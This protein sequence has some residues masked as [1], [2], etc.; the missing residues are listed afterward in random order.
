[1]LEIN[2][3]QYS[4]AIQINKDVEF[5][6]NGKDDA[7]RCPLHNPIV[8]DEVLDNLITFKWYN[9]EI[10]DS[11][12]KL[13][14]IRNV[15]VFH[16]GG[17]E[18]AKL[19]KFTSTKT[20]NGV[21]LYGLVPCSTYYFTFI[22]K[23][24]GNT[25]SCNPTATLKVDTN[26]VPP[27]RIADLRLTAPT[28][29]QIGVELVPIEPSL[30]S[31]CVP[32]FYFITLSTNSEKVE[33]ISTRNTSYQ[34]IGSFSPKTQYLVQVQAYYQDATNRGVALLKEII[35]PDE[36]RTV[37]R[38]PV[39]S[40]VTIAEVGSNSMRV[41]WKMS[42]PNS[43]GVYIFVRVLQ[44]GV[45][46][47]QM[48]TVF[49]LSIDS[50]VIRDLLPCNEY[51]VTIVQ[52]RIANRVEIVGQVMK[53]STRT[54]LPDSNSLLPETLT[55]THP[56]D[57][58]K[59]SLTIYTK[60]D[61]KCNPIKVDY[62]VE[63]YAMRPEITTPFYQMKHVVTS[64]KSGVEITWTDIQTVTLDG[65]I[66]VATATN[67]AKQWIKVDPKLR[68]AN[69]TNLAPCEKYRIFVYARSSE[70]SMSEVS[71]TVVVEM[72]FRLPTPSSA[73]LYQNGPSSLQ[74]FINGQNPNCA[75]FFQAQL[76]INS[77]VVQTIS[78]SDRKIIFKDLKRDTSYIARVSIVS[79][80]STP[81]SSEPVLSQS[82][83]LIDNPN[84]LPGLT[85][86]LQTLI[87][88]PDG[89]FIGFLPDFLNSTS[90]EFRIVQSMFCNS[91][92]HILENSVTAMAISSC[93]VQSLIR[94]S[95]SVTI[96]VAF[97]VV[98][99]GQIPFTHLLQPSL[100]KGDQ[101][102]T[103]TKTIMIPDFGDMIT[104]ASKVNRIG[105]FHI[106]L[107]FFLV[108]SYP[109]RKHATNLPSA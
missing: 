43:A 94:S 33:S 74:L 109:I 82:V 21:T 3:N 7:L 104:W 66:A 9:V 18:Y 56:N 86:T 14:D 10:L 15:D 106:V 108:F 49:N 77:T 100:I 6:S 96:S 31:P 37:V 83:Q 89:E 12:L 87:E 75:A 47:V 23:N 2:S 55:I 78:S 64:T 25:A 91:L 39:P 92:Q 46:L 107:S 97:N 41:D 62:D 50:I 53:P 63:V 54:T 38:P 105:K 73:F 34:F 48:N 13:V 4:D 29:N 40:D 19:T 35:V 67:G 90:L 5:V 1:T 17:F 93:S 95:T 27:Q 58:E 60:L 30:I 45:A 32:L 102:S 57:R 68:K 61:I 71:E 44:T 26:P 28:N 69:F 20:L 98:D 51:A 70:S 52:V 81:S 24:P 36:K 79:I 22:F 59:S 76:L 103:Y 88:R 65:Y 8:I 72:D 80:R 42:D 85:V 16:Q 84:T 99:F 11:E 101:V